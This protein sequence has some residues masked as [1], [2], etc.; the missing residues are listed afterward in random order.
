MIQFAYTHNFNRVQCEQYEKGCNISIK[1]LAKI[2]SYHDLT[3]NG[4]VDGRF[5]AMK[6]ISSYL[7]F[8]RCPIVL[9]LSGIKF[10]SFTTSTCHVFST[11]P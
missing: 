9:I 5:D 1:T 11:L 6:S 10:T 4:F 2:L 8:R 3:L 7:N